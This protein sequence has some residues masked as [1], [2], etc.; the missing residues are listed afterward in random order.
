M[1]WAPGL[2]SGQVSVPAEARGRIEAMAT[3]IA[4]RRFE[5]PTEWQGEEFPNPA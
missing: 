1:G 5:V 2:A 4:A 3:E